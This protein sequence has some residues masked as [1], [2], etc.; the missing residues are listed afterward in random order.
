MKLYEFYDRVIETSGLQVMTIGSL[1]AAI[2]NCM[3]DLTSRGYKNFQEKQLANMNPVI[4]DCLAILDAPRDIRK[5]LYLKAFFTNTSIKAE[6]YSLTN[7]RVQCTRVGDQYVSIIPSNGCI[8]YIKDDK[9]YIEWDRALGDLIDVF[10][11]YYARLVAPEI[12]DNIDTNSEEF[13]KY[14]INIREEFEDALVFYSC[15]FYYARF[16]KDTDKMQFFLNQ[17]KYYV[18]DIIHEISY[19]DDFYEEDVIIKV[20]E[21]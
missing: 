1:R 21:L 3:A 6:R 9:I 20:E 4:K 7:P 5:T 2:K 10:F 13:M 18:E 17:Y 19:E 14:N 8:Y 12:P 16:L 11:G 15:Y